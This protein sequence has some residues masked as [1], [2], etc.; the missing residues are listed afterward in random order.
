[1]ANVKSLHTILI[2]F[3]CFF[4]F[5]CKHGQTEEPFVD[6]IHISIHFDSDTYDYD[7]GCFYCSIPEALKTLDNVN[8]YYND[9]EALG[10]TLV[11]GL[12]SQGIKKYNKRI[13]RYYII[14]KIVIW[15]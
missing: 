7:K 3:L 8:L 5:S 14:D 11:Q 1:M 9:S 4:L 15:I 12:V 10:E 6:D 2:F 13:F